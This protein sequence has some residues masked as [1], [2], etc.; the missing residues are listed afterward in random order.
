MYFPS[1]YINLFRS[2][3]ELCAEHFPVGS[4]I[5]S[6]SRLSSSLFEYEDVHSLFPTG[7]CSSVLV[8]FG[9]RI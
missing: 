7:L 8:D 1:L 6:I 9:L 2:Q 3:L 4:L 5:A